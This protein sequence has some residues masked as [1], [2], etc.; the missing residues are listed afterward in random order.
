MLGVST[1]SRFA[2][3]C[4]AAT[5][6]TTGIGTCRAGGAAACGVA[7]CPTWQIWQVCSLEACACQCASA[8]VV[9]APN[10]RTSATAST[11]R[12]AIRFAIPKLDPAPGPIVA[13]FGAP[14]ATL[15]ALLV[16]LIGI[17]ASPG[18][19]ARSV[20]DVRTTRTSTICIVAALRN[21]GASSRQPQPS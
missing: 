15:V 18:G 14:G 17:T 7:T 8:C 11:R 1:G 3:K 16:A 9:S 2:T 13:K 19:I 20:M 6:F 12:I 10:V 21:P 4:S 5:N